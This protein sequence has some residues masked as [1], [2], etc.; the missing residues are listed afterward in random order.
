MNCFYFD[1]I[2]KK[3]NTANKITLFRGGT[4]FFIRAHF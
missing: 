1:L 4:C 2:T 3:K